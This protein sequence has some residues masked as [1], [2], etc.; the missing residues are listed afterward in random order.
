[1]DI[2]HRE[3]EK[4]TG[5]EDEA[6]KLGGAV[7]GFRGIEDKWLGVGAEEGNWYRSQGGSGL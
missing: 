6:G 1:M 2:S 7:D 4:H 5:I 3:I